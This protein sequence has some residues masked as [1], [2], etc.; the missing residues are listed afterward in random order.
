MELNVGISFASDISV[1]CEVAS[2]RLKQYE[3]EDLNLK[4]HFS[5]VYCDSR[6]LS[7]VEEKFKDFVSNW[8]WDNIDI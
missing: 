7:S 2:G 4:R 3:I 1:K 5:L 6:Y 8:K